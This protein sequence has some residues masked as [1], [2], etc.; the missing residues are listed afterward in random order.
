MNG[1]TTETGRESRPPGRSNAWVRARPEIKIVETYRY[2]CK[3]YE[4][5]ACD[6]AK[7]PDGRP[8]AGGVVEVVLPFVGAGRGEPGF[9]ASAQADVTALMAAGQAQT[10]RVG[11]LMLFQHLPKER[12]SATALAPPEI[13]FESLPATRRSGILPLDFP[14]SLYTQLCRSRSDLV[15]TFPY[16][17]TGEPTVKPT[18]YVEAKADRLLPFVRD[19]YIDL[20]VFRILVAVRNVAAIPKVQEASLT[21]PFKY[22]WALD[23]DPV[24]TGGAETGSEP[25]GESETG[26][27]PFRATGV[28]YH[29]PTQRVHWPREPVGVLTES[30]DGKDWIGLRLPFYET[31]RLLDLAELRGLVRLKFEDV[32]ASGL[33]ARLFSASGQSA[34][35]GPRGRAATVRKETIVEI[36][37][38]VDLGGILTRS[39]RWMRREWVF[40]GVLPDLQRVQDV[41]SALTDVGIR[42]K[43]PAAP[44]DPRGH[45]F[46]CECS[47]SGD[48]AHIL[49]D[50]RGE[51]TAGRQR[52]EQLDGGYTR[53]VEIGRV[54]IVVKAAHPDAA[55]LS[56][57]L[58]R[59][60]LKL[61]DT[62]TPHR[63][64]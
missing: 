5:T 29:A 49:V 45:Q 58:N 30:E 10:A 63:I 46:D 26:G 47:L 31:S 51:T 32:L 44:R 59:L 42:V 60:H 43:D 40:D 22:F 8:A 28:L 16:E 12:E 52:I 34:A 61:A 6:R 27:A 7:G 9:D 25:E 48:V 62:L 14:V 55:R 38:E 23:C 64:L 56:A 3:L 20:E 21:V 17:L 1:H 24:A 37:L 54:T 13:V 39:S 36:E 53:R 33:E 2:R 19:R 4:T 57:L 41:E 35:T 15:A 18:L 50:Y 11:Y